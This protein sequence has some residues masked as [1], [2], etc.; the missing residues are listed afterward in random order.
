MA[1]DQWLGVRGKRVKRGDRTCTGATKIALGFTRRR[2]I[3][4]Y[5]AA[6]YNSLWR[7]FGVF[8][9]NPS[10]YCLQGVGF[11]QGTARGPSPTSGI[12]VSRAFVIQL[13]IAGDEAEFRSHYL[14]QKSSSQSKRTTHL[15]GWKGNGAMRYLRIVLILVLVGVSNLVFADLKIRR[16]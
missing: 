5:V 7:F 10:A 11:N 12:R 4:Q 3:V 16:V 1:S 13:C 15:F 14:S 6:A 8:L 9:F 2:R